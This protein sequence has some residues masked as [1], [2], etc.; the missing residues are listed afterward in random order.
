MQLLIT[1]KQP[2]EITTESRGPAAVVCNGYRQRG[3]TPGPCTCT[4]LA[5][6]YPG[7]GNLRHFL[8]ETRAAVS[9]QTRVHVSKQCTTHMEHGQ[10][11]PSGDVAVYTFTYLTHITSIID[12]QEMIFM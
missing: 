11:L 9:S 1:C 2:P 12:V 4:V 3:F 10:T 7:P 8:R 6:G 5:D